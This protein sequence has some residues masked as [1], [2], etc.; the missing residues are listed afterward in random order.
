MDENILVEYI[1]ICRSIL[2]N[3]WFYEGLDRI[4]CTHIRGGGKPHLGGGKPHLGGGK[5][6]LG[7]GKPMM[8]WG[9]FS[10]GAPTS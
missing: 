8:K 5:P 7:G 4:H 6:H 1:F 3:L 9:S 2:L 10:I